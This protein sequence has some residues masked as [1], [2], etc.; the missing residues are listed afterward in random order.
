[1]GELAIQDE[2]IIK[3]GRKYQPH[4]YEEH[5]GC[6]HDHTHEGHDHGSHPH[7]HGHGEHCGCGH[8]Y[9]HEGRRHEPIE[10]RLANHAFDGVKKQIYIIENLG[11]ANCAAKM[12]RKIQDL[13]QVDYANLIYATRQLQIVTNTN[14]ELLSVFQEIC[15][16]IEDGV[17]VTKQEIKQA[18]SERKAAEREKAKENKKDIWELGIGA[19]LMTAGVVTERYSMAVSAVLLIIAYLILGRHVLLT[20]GKNIIKGHVFDENFL[21][22]IATLGAF[23]IQDYKEA[24]GVMLFYRVGPATGS[25][26]MG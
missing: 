20:A 23:A 7:S 22:S 21:M 25:R 18:A 17:T 19:V 10:P 9:G 1:M 8:D 3:S 12:E 13:P 11:C 14:E 16:S 2:E 26:W 4:D 24:V 6:G 5:C 15:A